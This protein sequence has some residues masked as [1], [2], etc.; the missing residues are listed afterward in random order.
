MDEP[1]AAA[2][3][4][5]SRSE[6]FDALRHDVTAHAAEHGCGFVPAPATDLR[7]LEV[8]TRATH[9]SYVLQVGAGLGEG[10]LHIADAFGRTGRLDVI[11]PEAPHA[12]FIE[13]AVQRFALDEV[14]RVNN[15]PAVEVITGL[16]GPYDLV[17]FHGSLRAFDAAYEDVI[18]LLRTGGSLAIVGATARDAGEGSGLARLAGESRMLPWFAPGLVRILATRVR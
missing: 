7:E 2:A 3:L 8:L 10:A 5:G 6:R 14:V 11:E 12:A 9:S 15:A 16:S 17:V 4:T 13:R 18:R 1:D